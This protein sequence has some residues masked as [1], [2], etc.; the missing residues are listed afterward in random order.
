M[1]ERVSLR[2]KRT[3]PQVDDLQSFDSSLWFAWWYPAG[4]R[5]QTWLPGAV[6]DTPARKNIRRSLCESAI[7]LRRSAGEASF[8]AY[9]IDVVALLIDRL[10]DLTIVLCYKRR[11]TVIVNGARF[12]YHFRSIGRSNRAVCQEKLL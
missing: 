8:L 5:S 7:R 9:K 12:S 6:A 4:I 10:L 11:S 1:R 2:G 3:S